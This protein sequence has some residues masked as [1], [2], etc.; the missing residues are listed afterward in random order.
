M[1][2]KKLQILVPHYNEPEE[3]VKPLLD[4]IALQ[5]GIDFDEIGVIICN[6]GLG[7][8]LSKD[9][10]SSYPFKIDYS[11]EHHRGIS[12]TR[13][14]CLEKATAEYVM[15]CDSDD[16]FCFMLGL[17]QIFQEM[18]KGFDALT[19]LLVQELKNTETGELFYEN[20]ELDGIFVHGK[21]FRREFLMKNEIWFDERLN[22]CCE[23]SYFVS[24][25]LSVSQ[26]TVYCPVP[27]YMWKYHVGS[28]SHR[29]SDYEAKAYRYIVESNRYLLDDLLARGLHD[30]AVTYAASLIIN[31][32][33]AIKDPNT[34]GP[35]QAQYAAETEQLISE[36]C[37]K[38]RHLYEE[39]PL[40][41]KERILDYVYDEFDHSDTQQAIFQINRWLNSVE[42]KYN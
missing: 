12:A 3:V 15:F 20:R 31:V 9:F 29:D 16:M 1:D 30:K 28:V 24:L 23:D 22:V 5:R 26:N 13:N 36:W 38:Y 37:R 19:S 7:V 6:D 35:D 11:I 18:E 27:F 10:L 40:D 21:V 25:C 41:E 8:K 4:S 17:R 39:S 14:S 34:F 32:Y 2:R 33:G 42:H